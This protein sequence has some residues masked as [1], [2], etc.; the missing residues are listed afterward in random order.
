MGICS[1][2][3]NAKV[4]PDIVKKDSDIVYK[5]CSICLN[6]ITNNIA[7]CNCGCDIIYHKSC[8]LK[9]VNVKSTCPICKKKILKRKL[10]IDKKK[11]YFTKD[12][13]IITE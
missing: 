1:S 2:K 3:N 8:L 13:D 6:E 9:W 7:K 4:H 11:P 10:N 12:Y 5:I